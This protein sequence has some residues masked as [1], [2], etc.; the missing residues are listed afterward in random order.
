MLP[1]NLDLDVLRTL[2]AAQRLG[3][4][5]RAAE[6]VGRSQSAVS[7]QIHRLE[8]RIGQKLFR[9]RGR[10]LEPTEAGEMVL[11]YARRLL[12]L[13]D[14]AVAAVRGVAVEGAVRFGLPGDFAETWLPMALGRFKRAHPGVL[15]E[16]VVDRNTLLLE[17]LDAGQLDLVVA[18][19]L[20]AR[21]DADPIATLPLAW[22]GPA[23]DELPWRA[24]EPVP[25][26]VFAV[27]CFFRHTATQA[28]DAAGRA[29]TV[30]FTSPSLPGLWAAVAAG[31][32]I[33]LRTTAGLPDTLRVLGAAEGL[34]K[35]PELG[36][37]M[38]DGGRA[39]SPAAQKLKVIMLQVLA[40]NIA[41]MPGARLALREGA[42]PEGIPPHVSARAKSG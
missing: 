17:Q 16:A 10:A 9:K 36:L 39:L 41:A 19:G 6:Q 38:H 37:A 29:W 1:I 13:N 8:E 4:F 26:A 20:A 40:D 30:T 33:T 25:L 22:I 28:L 3:G 15:V 14:E 12:E 18:L 11:S 32:G 34:P 5:N 27:P 42:I 24:G 7:Q 2:V 21:D 35:L 31:L 23:G